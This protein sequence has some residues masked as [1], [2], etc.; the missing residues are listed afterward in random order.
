M[1]Q[2]KKQIRQI[3][4]TNTDGNE[5]VNFK[6]LYKNFLDGFRMGS[7]I[8]LRFYIFLQVAHHIDDDSNPLGSEKLP[9]ILLLEEF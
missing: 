3:Q 9:I 8:Y 4:R 7:S 5:N 6:S 1:F 2:S